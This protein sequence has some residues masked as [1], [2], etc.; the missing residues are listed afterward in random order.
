MEGSLGNVWWTQ[1][2]RSN[3]RRI[4]IDYD[5]ARECETIETS[6][7]ETI[8]ASC[9]EQRRGKGKSKGKDNRNLAWV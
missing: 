1:S 6:D 5:E 3:V 7:T 9:G 4:Q 8:H 2:A